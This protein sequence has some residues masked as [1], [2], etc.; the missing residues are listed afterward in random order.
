[1]TPLKTCYDTLNYANAEIRAWAVRMAWMNQH[2]SR[3]HF[4]LKR[5]LVNVVRNRASISLILIS[6][7][8]EQP[9]FYNYILALAAITE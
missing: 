1:M 3:D 5:A 6:K 4:M 8:K 9:W 2:F 7:K